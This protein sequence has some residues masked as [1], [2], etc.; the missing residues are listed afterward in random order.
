MI[1][2]TVE[3]LSTQPAGEVAGLVDGVDPRRGDQHEAG[4]VAVQQL[5]H[6][7]GAIAEPGLHPVERLE[8]RER[9]G[10]HLAADRPC[11]S[12]AGSAAWRR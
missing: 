11:R 5:D 12:I 3:S 8:E 1:A 9:I 2:P 7:V 6:L 4:A 10:E